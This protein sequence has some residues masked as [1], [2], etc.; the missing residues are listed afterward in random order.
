MATPDLDALLAV[1]APLRDGDDARVKMVHLETGAPKVI[2]LKLDL[3]YWPTWSL[4]FCDQTYAWQRTTI[5]S[6]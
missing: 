4:T 6:V 5:S 1:V 3:K 2:T